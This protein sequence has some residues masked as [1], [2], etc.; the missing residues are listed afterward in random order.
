MNFDY[1]TRMRRGVPA[2]WRS[3]GHQ[4]RLAAPPE[5]HAAR[6]SASQ[7]HPL[8]PQRSGLAEQARVSDMH[9][10]QTLLQRSARSLAASK[11]LPTHALLHTKRLS[12]WHI[13]WPN[14][15]QSLPQS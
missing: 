5:L 4:P 7:P 13:R 12:S 6:R 11:L 15:P 14:A 2:L 10:N 3:L 9:Q 8:P 1:D